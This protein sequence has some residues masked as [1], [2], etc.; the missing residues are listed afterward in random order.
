MTGGMAYIYDEK[1]DFE[2]AVNPDSVVW[3]RFGSA[4]YEAQCKE[5]IERHAAETGSEFAKKLLV[6]WELERGK[7]WQ[8]I[9]KEM[10]SR[11]E[12]P[13]MDEAAE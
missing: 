3:Q 10:L 8:I 12:V 11:L 4:H 2:H 9:P 5:L 13:L 6:D 7:F 1:G